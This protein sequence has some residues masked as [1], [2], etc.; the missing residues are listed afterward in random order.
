MIAMTSQLNTDLEKVLDWCVGKN[1]S[2]A[3]LLGLSGIREDHMMANFATLA[4]YSNNGGFV[5]AVV[6]DSNQQHEL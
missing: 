1:V 2:S 4:D 6:I 5:A 3:T